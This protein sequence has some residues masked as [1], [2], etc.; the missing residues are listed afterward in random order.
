MGGIGRR[1][2]FT[3]MRRRARQRSAVL[4]ARHYGRLP[5]SRPVSDNEIS[6]D[7]GCAL[8]K[9]DLRS[10]TAA[11][12]R[13]GEV[14]VSTSISGLPCGAKPIETVGGSLDDRKKIALAEGERPG[15]KQGGALSCFEASGRGRP[16][17]LVIQQS[18]PRDG[19]D[20][21]IVATLAGDLAKGYDGDPGNC[22]A[23]IEDV[24]GGL[25]RLGVC[26]SRLRRLIETTG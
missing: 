18:A 1:S 17:A 21:W 8:R 13:A 5:F 22:R 12:G 15:R 14:S 9:L 24:I 25:V 6:G 2:N 23:H 20:A 11:E 16:P 26:P 7:L 10:N 4:S 19:S 3:V